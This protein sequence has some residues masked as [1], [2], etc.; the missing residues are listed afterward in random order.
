MARARPT[1][2]TRAPEETRPEDAD[3]STAPLPGEPD[4]VWPAWENTSDEDIERDTYGPRRQRELA[5]A[6]R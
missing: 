1:P 3:A 5:R 6:A 2:K 4:E